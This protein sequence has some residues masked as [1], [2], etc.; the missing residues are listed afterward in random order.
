[1]TKGM[2]KVL[3][4]FFLVSCTYKS[5]Q[6]LSHI[7]EEESQVENLEVENDEEDEIIVKII[8][9]KEKQE[10]VLTIERSAT[11]TF[12][13]EEIYYAPFKS[14]GLYG[15]IDEGLNVKVIP[16]Y[17]EI[18]KM[19]DGFY[20]HNNESSGE[21]YNDNLNLVYS[22]DSILFRGT[23]FF[24][25]KKY[26]EGDNSKYTVNLKNG[27][28]KVIEPNK[29]YNKTYFYNSDKGIVIEQNE[30]AKKPW[31]FSVG[32]LD[33]NIIA[34]NI[35]QGYPSFSEGL[36]AI[37]FFEGKSGFLDENGNL[38]IETPLYFDLDWEGP[39][40]DPVLPYYF[41]EDRAVVRVDAKEW[42]ILDKNGNSFSIPDGLTPSCYSFSE[43][44][45]RLKS[46]SDQNRIG[47]M[48]KEMEISIP[49]VFDEAEDFINGY[50]V[51]VYE[52][53]DAVLDKKG[54]VYL[55]KDLLDEKKDVFVNV[56]KE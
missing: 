16:K 34:R 22:S 51:V 49:Y 13:F 47:Y 30:L 19:K 25:Q 54:N 35:D 37:I 17:Q 50:A 20:C 12:S 24:D 5:R 11:Y 44:F 8:E 56:M 18:T 27:E 46:K 3:L 32:D 33:G 4:L 23:Y 40:K 39:R 21:Y 7:P 29:Y 28:I 15:F 26:Y 45:L 48:N 53:E 31:T 14:D 43:G 38:T 41:H 2:L 1:M 36:I 52:G 42:I 9:E 6:D 10:D 55:S